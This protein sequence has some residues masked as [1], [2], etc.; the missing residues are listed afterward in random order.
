MPV[1]PSLVL[2]KRLISDILD[3]IGCTIHYDISVQI[4][5]GSQIWGSGE[6]KGF[7]AV[8]YY[9]VRIT[10]KSNPSEI[11]A[12][13]DLGLKELE[14]RFVETHKQGRPIV[15]NGKTIVA[16]DLDRIEIH[17]TNELS[18]E[19]GQL[20]RA[21]EIEIGQASPSDDEWG[22]SAPTLAQ[23]G[24]DVTN[25]YIVEAPG[26]SS[27]S[28]KETTAT[29]SRPPANAREVF[30]VH[31]RNDA[32][33]EAMFFFLKS[34]G[35][36]PLEW[37]EAIRLTGKSAPYVGEILDA[38]FSRA[39]A[40]V[41]LFTAD[42]LA[43]LK[44]Q[45]Q[46]DDEPE[47][48]TRL[49]GQARPNVLF[50]A[51][52]ALGRAQEQTVL[53]ELGKLRPFSDVAGRHFVRLDNSEDRRRDLA[54]R[55]ANAGCAV[56]LD[57]DKWLT[58]GD[59]EEAV[60]AESPV[61]LEAPDGVVNVGIDARLSADAKRLLLAAANKEERMIVVLRAGGG[62]VLRIGGRTFV[63]AEDA[64]SIARWESVISELL[65]L[66]LIKQYA[67]S[68]EAYEVTNQGFLVAMSLGKTI[69]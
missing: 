34:I 29:E 68:G 62:A 32:A 15:I 52:M 53:I 61:S 44:L 63:D 1:T 6:D 5:Y 24:S 20:L 2:P 38:A 10:P 13:L 8:P 30:V 16:S 23:Q 11:E 35:L 59:F 26:Q 4:C 69:E 25:K 46:S 12:V 66:G 56:I 41:V 50:E 45:F 39:R 49:T 3:S 27:E 33:R 60:T 37:S 36:L 47:Y 9:H 51:G 40:V 22:Y 28:E 42:D 65:T 57:E 14:E 58:A 7:A 43:L 18:S 55:L 31:G 48:E 17:E 19:M 64:M 21:Y 67:G 54:N